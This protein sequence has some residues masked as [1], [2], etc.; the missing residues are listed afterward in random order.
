MTKQLQ[1]KVN[2][3]C[4]IAFGNPDWHND[5]RFRRV[6]YFLSY[7][8][9]YL[10]HEDPPSFAEFRSYLITAFKLLQEKARDNI[11]KNLMDL[12]DTE[13]KQLTDNLKQVWSREM[14]YFEWM[15][16]SLE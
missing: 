16:W 4:A 10:P 5:Q 8:P 11:G 1:E 13:L 15:L 14:F 2:L 12:R 3:I 9:R 7:I 6:L